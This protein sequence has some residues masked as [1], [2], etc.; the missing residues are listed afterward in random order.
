MYGTSVFDAGGR[1]LDIS[2]VIILILFA[3][4]LIGNEETVDAAA[5]ALIM[6]QHIDIKWIIR[7]RGGNILNR[8]HME[9]YGDEEDDDSDGR[10]KQQKKVKQEKPNNKKM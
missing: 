7:T 3:I 5:G 2:I 10:K 1:I 9:V 4:W 8:K 6:A